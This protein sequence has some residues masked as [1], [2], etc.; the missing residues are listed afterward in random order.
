MTVVGRG[1]TL[2]AAREAAY[3]GVAEV[4]LEGGTYRTDI[5]AGALDLGDRAQLHDEAR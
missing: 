5:G 4:R 3:R 1:Q 2:E